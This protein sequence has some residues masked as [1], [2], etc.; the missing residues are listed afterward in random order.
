[1]KAEAAGNRGTRALEHGTRTELSAGKSAGEA[2]QRLELCSFGWASHV[3]VQ[4]GYGRGRPSVW[5]QHSD[6]EKSPP[7][8]PPSAPS[9]LVDA[10]GHDGTRN[11]PDLERPFRRL[12]KTG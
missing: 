5:E 7:T 6:S 1:L 12:L 9:R 10:K 8:S 3:V 11:R 2:V 4:R